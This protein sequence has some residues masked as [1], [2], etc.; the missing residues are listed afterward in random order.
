[1]LVLALLLVNGSLPMAQDDLMAA[2][3]AYRRC[4]QEQLQSAS[5]ATSDDA[6]AAALSRCATQEGAM[7]DAY[8]RIASQLPPSSDGTSL[9]SHVRQFVGKRREELR[10]ELT[11]LAKS[12][13]P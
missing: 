13:A 11:A 6:V 7:A 12:N 8:R 10:F 3:M 2:I 5:A 9:E 4:G 1:M